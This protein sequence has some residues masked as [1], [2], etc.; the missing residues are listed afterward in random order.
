MHM[1]VQE[2]GWERTLFPDWRACCVRPFHSIQLRLAGT[3][4]RLA[5]GLFSSGVIRRL[6]FL[7]IAFPSRSSVR[8]GSIDRSSCRPEGQN[9]HKKA[10][11]PN[12]SPGSAR[13]HYVVD[14][15][16]SVR[17][18]RTTQP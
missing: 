17:V 8:F 14:L 6:C 5:P 13:W 10:T 11:S 12:V 7:L 3:N 18:H 9:T 2:G 1:H 15:A 4:A 16:V